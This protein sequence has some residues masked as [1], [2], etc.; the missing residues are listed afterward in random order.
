MVGVVELELVGERVLLCAGGRESSTAPPRVPLLLEHHH[1]RPLPNHEARALGVKRA[2][3]AGRGGGVVVG[4]GEGAR[5]RKAGDRQRLDARLCAT[6]ERRCCP[7][8]RGSGRH[9]ARMC[10]SAPPA[11]TTSASPERIMPSP[12]ASACAPV[13]HAV[14]YAA[15]LGVMDMARTHV[16]LSRARGSPE[17]PTGRA[18][19]RGWR[20][21]RRDAGEM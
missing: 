3:R 11:T 2:R 20:P 6:E 9:A 8:T 4:R 13:A 18:S 12:S 19:P 16:A 17:L 10:A 15:S 14:A 21:G 7:R 5:A 1:R